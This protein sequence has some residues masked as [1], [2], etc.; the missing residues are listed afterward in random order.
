MR[1]RG[2][3]VTADYDKI[4]AGNFR[5][6]SYV[7]VPE[8]EAYFPEA[9]EFP[10]ANA[11]K[12]SMLQMIELKAPPSVAVPLHLP[13][14]PEAPAVAPSRGERLRSQRGG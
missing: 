1:Y 14:A 11:R 6:V 13:F 5:S 9:L 4:R 7:S 10:F 3:L 8:K 12:L 2:T